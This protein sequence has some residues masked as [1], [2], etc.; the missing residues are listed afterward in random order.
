MSTLF[1]SNIASG[2]QTFASWRHT[3]CE[4]FVE[5]ECQPQSRRP[6]VGEIRSIGASGLIFSTLRS[7]DQIVRRTN[8]NIRRDGK[9]LLL[10][11]L[12]LGGSCDLEQ[13]GRDTRLG[14]GDMACFD[15]TRPYM[16]NFC[17]DF[18]QLVIQV[19]NST[20]HDLI[21]PSS[22]FVS[23]KI[24]AT[25]P[26]SKLA[27]PFLRQTANSLGELG[28]NTAIG[29]VETSTSLLATA[30]SELVVDDVRAIRWGKDA[31]L[32]RAKAYIEQHL[33]DPDLDIDAIAQFMGISR[34]YLQELFQADDSTPTEFLWSRR[35][36]RSRRYLTDP[37]MT[38]ESI[39]QIAL[40]CGFKDFTHFSRR[41]KAR[42]LSTPRDC[43]RIALTG[44][45]GLN[46]AI[47]LGRKH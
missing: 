42:Y 22:R 6:F 11:L 41:F 5:H 25:S 40:A 4:T 38:G 19:P 1:P 32:C 44:H 18:E 24:S 30:F 17:D 31:L 33:Q 8:H 20:I 3:V 16:L 7:R 43:R 26:I 27:F 45:A 23:R 21:G 35:L 28:S 2:P 10:F 46:A 13:D 39:S 34:R 47:E 15:T 9:E 12:Q 14:P 36:E 37:L 29:V